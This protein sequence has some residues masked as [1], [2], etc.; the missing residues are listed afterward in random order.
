MSGSRNNTHYGAG[1]S[2]EPTTAPDTV[3]MQ[4]VPNSTQE[5]NVPSNPEGLF[6]AN[7][8][9]LAHGRNGT[10]WLKVTGTGTTGWQQVTNGTTVPLQFT[11]NSGIAT[12]AANNL[13]VLGNNTQGINITGAADTLTIAGINASATQKGV[14]SFNA[15]NFTA[16]SGA[17]TSNPITVTAGT[18]LTGGGS[19]NLGGSVTLNAAPSVP[20]TFNGNTGSATPALNILNVVGDTAQGVSTNATSNTVTTTVANATSSSKGV[21]SFN[22]TN[23]T[24]TSG[25]VASNAITINTGSGLSGGGT[26]NLGGSITLSASATPTNMVEQVLNL[27]ITY[28]AGTFSITAAD[29]TALSVSN[30]GYVRIPSA[31]AGQSLVYTITANQ[32]FNDSTAGT[33][34]GNNLFGLT[35]GIAYAQDIPFFIYAV[36]NDAQNAVNFAISRIPHRTRAPASTRYAQQGSTLA[37]TQGSFFGMG[38]FVTTDYDQN[39]CV[40][41]GAFRMRYT[42]SNWTVQTLSNGNL[43]AVTAE[44]IQADGIM[45]FHDGSKFQ[46][47]TGQFGNA[48]GK[49]FRNNGGTA[50]TFTN[51]GLD[52]QIMRNGY[53]RTNLN[54]D[55]AS[56]GS[57][58]QNLTFSLFYNSAHT[59]SIGTVC[60]GSGTGTFSNSA[61]LTGANF[62]TVI[63][64]TFGGYLSN[65]SLNGAFFSLQLLYMADPN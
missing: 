65:I 34:I 12:P 56:G 54:S 26:V 49:Y 31:T 40:C 64:P 51:G 5:L 39:P 1:Y 15:T 38:A 7:P 18:G 42:G 23:F 27:G 61:L 8:G 28:S 45:Q 19:V 30:P 63:F 4:I 46:V 20:T 17:I 13:N 41:I 48:A 36:A 2:M 6:A 16:T 21:A 33:N 52:Y 58:S 50:P 35:T 59:G 3:T 62:S 25:A 57:G 37:S 55:T 47:P 11:S 44:I 29:G 53:I 24:V 60:G 22:S 43:G 32:S 10:L 9:S 14:A